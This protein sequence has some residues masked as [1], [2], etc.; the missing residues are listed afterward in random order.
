MV[1]VIKETNTVKKM[2][3]HVACGISSPWRKMKYGLGII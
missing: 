1:Y 3:C 2:L